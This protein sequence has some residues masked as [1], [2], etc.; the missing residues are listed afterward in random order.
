MNECKDWKT[1][2]NI[3]SYADGEERGRLGFDTRL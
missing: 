3:C 1:D 2:V